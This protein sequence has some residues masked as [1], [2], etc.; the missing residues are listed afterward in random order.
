MMRAFSKAAFS[1]GCLCAAPAVLLVLFILLVCSNAIFSHAHLFLSFQKS[2][3]RFEA[4]ALT[5][6]LPPP[7][8]ATWLGKSKLVHL[9]YVC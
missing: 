1:K 2:G 3:P 8:T 7:L 9:P 6:L 4:T 5:I